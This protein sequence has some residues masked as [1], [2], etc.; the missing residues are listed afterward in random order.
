[1]TDMNQAHLIGRL[2]AD[3]NITTTKDGKAVAKFTLAVS[4]GKTKEGSELTDFIGC[5]AFDKIAEKIGEW[6]K[7]GHR[8]AVTTRQQTGNYTNKDGQK[9]YTHDNV[10]LSWQTLE[11]KQDNGNGS[12][13]A[14]NSND[15][16]AGFQ[17]IEENEQDEVPFE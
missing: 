5:V 6:T 7:K 16:M 10:V 15:V 9:V 13:P 1:M 2:T 4:R 11:K 12:K 14:P 17:D 3:A 8:I